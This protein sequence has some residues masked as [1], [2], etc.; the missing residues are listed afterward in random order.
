VNASPAA[1]NAAAAAAAAKIADEASSQRKQHRAR[2]AA[3][4]GKDVSL[5]ERCQISASIAD[6][7]ATFHSRLFRLVVT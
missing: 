6:E 3:L 1:V 4:S 2:A 7:T 5:I